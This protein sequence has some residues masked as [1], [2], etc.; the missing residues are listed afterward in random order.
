MKELDIKATIY[1]IFGYL[2]PGLLVLGIFYSSYLNSVSKFN[3]NAIITFINTL[4]AKGFTILFFISY[5]LGHALSTLSSFIVEKKIVFKYFYKFIYANGI[6][7]NGLYNNL[8]TKY[9]RVFNNNYSDKDFR[10]IIC[11][12]ESKQPAIYSTA[13]V[14]LSFYGMARSLGFVLSIGL[15]WELYNFLILS[16]KDSIWFGIVYLVLGIVFYLQYYKFIRYYREQIFMGF[17]LNDE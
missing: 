10:L 1:D 6:L 11:F 17:I 8:I 15:L 7:S 4:T 2:I 13:F 16:H 14:F 5:F 9:Q 12:V 3:L